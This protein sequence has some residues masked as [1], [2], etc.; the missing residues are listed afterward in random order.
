M[1]AAKQKYKSIVVSPSFKQTRIVNG[2]EVMETNSGDYYPRWLENFVEGILNPIP[3]ID[4]FRGRNGTV[5]LSP[6]ITRSCLQRDDRTNG[7]TDVMTWGEICFSGSKPYLLSVLTMNYGIEFADWKPFGKKEIAR[8]YS[9]DVLDYQ[10]IVGHLTKLD[11]LRNPTDDLFAIAQPTP[12]DQQIETAFVSTQKE[13][14]LLETAPTLDWP[15]V[16]EGKTEGYMIVY[17][18]TDRTG[19]VRETAKHNSDQPGL[20]QFGM[21]QALRYKFKPLVVNGVA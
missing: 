13:E 1:V 20:E 19:Q 11:E 2:N 6:Q 17:A 10:Q 15:T 5:M 21:E 3:M 18:R 4:N 12:A 8:S 14:S 9:T 7:I 16:H